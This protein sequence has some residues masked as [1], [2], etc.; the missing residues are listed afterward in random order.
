VFPSRQ[1]TGLLRNWESVNISGG[2]ALWTDDPRAI[3]VVVPDKT[4]RCAFLARAHGYGR[5]AALA[6]RSP[7]ET[8]AMA[9][10]G[11]SAFA[12]DLFEWLAAAPKEI[13]DMDGDGLTDA[14]EDR[15]NNGKTDPGETNYLNA[16]SDGDGI[17]DG[18][19]DANRNGVVDDG[20]TSPLNFDSDSDGISDGADE[21][22]VPRTDAPQL[23][24]MTPAEGPAEGGTSVTLSGKNL[25]PDSDVMFGN[26]RAAAV[27]LLRSNHLLVETPPCKDAQGTVTDVT[28]SLE[29]GGKTMTCS[30]PSGF[31]YTERSR[32]R[33]V[34]R[35]FEAIAKQKD[36]Y[37][38]E[39][40]VSLEVPPRVNLGQ[41]LLTISPTPAP[42]L[43]W[44]EPKV[45]NAR[46][47]DPAIV[48]KVLPESN[49][50]LLA[51]SGKRGQRL[52]GEIVV[53]PWTSTLP[54]A[55]LRFELLKPVVRTRSNQLLDV[56]SEIQ[57]VAPDTGNVKRLDQEL[58]P[59]DQSNSR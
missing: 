41:A 10:P 2:C 8:A 20:E 32:A 55:N 13:Q 44:G 18:L 3:R 50:M 6:G 7:F 56:T 59:G 51:T 28:L 19:E 33:V 35:V 53:I 52:G 57:T 4:D 49:R 25:T 45:R 17:P 54:I 29:A 23:F 16:D 46:N 40:S 5:I 30:L 34:L 24:A 39:I 26:R 42:A 22:P 21:S 47:A 11:A 36:L 9:L 37:A 12:D 43:T 58:S 27:R 31:R 14:L 48:S 38:G 1:R 15:K